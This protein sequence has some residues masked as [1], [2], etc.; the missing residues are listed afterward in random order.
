MKKIYAYIFIKMKHKE[1]KLQSYCVKYFRNNYPEYA[2]LYFSVPN[3]RDRDELGGEYAETLGVIPGVPD[4]I[5]LVPRKGY[6][7]LCIEF[8]YGKYKQSDDQV[9]WQK[10]A[11]D[12]CAKYVICRS[13]QDFIKEIG[14]YL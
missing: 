12:E 8:K 7:C 14:D 4:T 9:L 5:L 2:L 13:I 11:E 6:T 3:N 10:A 1:S